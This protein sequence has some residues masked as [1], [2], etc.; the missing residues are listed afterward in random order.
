MNLRTLICTAAG[1]LAVIFL[2]IMTPSHSL[3]PK[4]ILLPA[5]LPIRSPINPDQVTLYIQTPQANFTQLGSVSVEQ[6]FSELDDETKNLLV[7][8]VKALAANAG[9]NG[10]LV[11]VLVPSSGVRQMMVFRGTAI[12]ISTASN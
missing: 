12:H 10:V 11:N 4:G 7:Q 2:M 1:L 3:L 6:G 9:A 5:N 8:K